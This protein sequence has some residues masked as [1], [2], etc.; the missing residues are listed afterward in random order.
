MLGQ[1]KQQVFPPCR[2]YFW[3]NKEKE[4]RIVSTSLSDVLFCEKRNSL[5]P[6]G[7]RGKEQDVWIAVA[8]YWIVQIQK[9]KTYQNSKW[10]VL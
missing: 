3:T 10:N 9:G 4:D 6:C 1:Q 8:R 5:V 2:E 7:F